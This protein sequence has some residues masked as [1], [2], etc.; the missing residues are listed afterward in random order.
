MMRAIL[1]TLCLPAFADL[2]RLNI[3]PGSVTISG[4]SS[5]AYMATQ[6]QVAYS[7][8]FAGTA[9]VAG[10]SYWC[11]EGDKIKAQI[12]CMGQPGMI[13]SETQIAEAR[14]L[15]TAGQID[16]PINLNRA[17]FFIFASSRDYVIRSGNSDKLVEFLQAFVPAQNISYVQD[18]VTGHGFPTLNYGASCA[19]G[20]APWLLNCER[21]LAGEILRDFYGP[22]DPPSKAGPLTPFAQTDFGSA[23]L[24]ANGWVYVPQACAAG[25]ACRLHVALHGCQMNPDFIQDQ[26][27]LH[28]GYNAWA[29]ANN[30]AVLYPQSAKVA[31][32]NP[33]ACWDWF[34]FT[35]KNYVSQDGPQMKAL[36]SMIRAVSG[37]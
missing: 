10:G 37:L 22:L 6:M 24:F 19:G 21:D 5:G 12:Q 34:G 23:P 14:R 31:G 11:A 27:A 20:G 15:F 36:R 26:F 30:I 13:R 16:D 18:G 25:K 2:P 28:A 3:Q 4:V 8:L 7:S 1:L 33:Y 35:G 32:D 29:E 9:S 17:K